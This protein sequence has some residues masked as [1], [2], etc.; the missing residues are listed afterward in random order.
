MSA[1]ST[2]NAGTIDASNTTHVS[3][4]RHYTVSE[5][6]ELWSLSDNTIRKVF[7]DEPGVLR[8][9]LPSLRARKRQNITL[10]IP[11]SVVYRVHGRM[12]VN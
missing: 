6:A 11:E 1:P 5:V 10:R 7:R 9:Q 8:T 4:E 3:M 2:W 12:S